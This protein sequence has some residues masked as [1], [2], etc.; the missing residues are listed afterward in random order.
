MIGGNTIKRPKVSS[1]QPEPLGA[2]TLRVSFK[3]C[4]ENPSRKKQMEGETHKGDGDK[5][6]A[7]TTETG[8][9]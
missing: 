5:T 4:K 2:Q 6:P 9:K 8:R 7:Q 1:K 3:D